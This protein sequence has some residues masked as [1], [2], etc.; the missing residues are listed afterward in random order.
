MK[1]TCFRFFGLLLSKGSILV[2]GPLS[3]LH[4][5]W[6][7]CAAPVG[8]A[9]FCLGPLHV[10]FSASWP[11]LRPAPWPCH[12]YFAVAFDV[13]TVRAFLPLAHFSGVTFLSLVCWAV[14]VCCFSGSAGK[15]GCVLLLG[16]QLRA[17][18]SVR[19][20][21]PDTCV[22]PAY[23][24][25]SSAVFTQA[26][27]VSLCCW[28]CLAVSSPSVHKRS[29]VG[30]AHQRWQCRFVIRMLGRY[31]WY[32]GISSHS[33]FSLVTLPFIGIL[34]LW[35]RFGFGKIFRLKLLGKLTG[36]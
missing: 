1:S 22:R 15:R 29:G 33:F 31:V 8:P 6:K 5:H 27:G 7:V 25:G 16:G 21:M 4:P 32:V 23:W 26:S 13:H 11:S 14:P 18:S 24:A 19:W 35:I 2:L 34:F 10:E 17:A 28:Y 20:Q 12:V 9:S 36:S 30:N 3:Y